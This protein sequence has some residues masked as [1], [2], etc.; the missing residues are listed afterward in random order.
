MIYSIA[1]ELESITPL[2]ELCPRPI[3]RPEEEDLQESFENNNFYKALD[4]KDFSTDRS[5][6]FH[7][8]TCG[9]QTRLRTK[10]AYCRHCGF[11]QSTL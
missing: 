7:C 9:G 3:L 1:Q 2:L 4:P 10:H 6:S 11:S 5:W 8:R